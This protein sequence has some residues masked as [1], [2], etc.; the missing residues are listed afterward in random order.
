ME[1]HIQAEEDGDLWGHSR[2]EVMRKEVR[3]NKVRKVGRELR[4]A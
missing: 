2:L 3:N 4:A 1:S